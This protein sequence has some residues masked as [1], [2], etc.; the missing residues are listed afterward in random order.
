M[1][2]SN[3]GGWQ[4]SSGEQSPEYTAVR[5]GMLVDNGT[6]YKFNGSTTPLGQ[7]DS[8]CDN[9]VFAFD[10][11]ED[12]D[13]EVIICSTSFGVA[14]DSG[15]LSPRL[16][17]T[18]D[19]GGFGIM[20]QMFLATDGPLSPPEGEILISSRLSL[21]NASQEV[22]INGLIPWAYG[23]QKPTYYKLKVI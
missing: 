16:P 22:L 15:Q 10:S 12:L 9:R 19:I 4:T 21:L 17:L 8:V 20:P 11:A 2:G 6:L 14:I 13:D 5:G 18:V 3:N 7:I 1:V 23:N